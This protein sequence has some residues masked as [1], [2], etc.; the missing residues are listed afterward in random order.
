MDPNSQLYGEDLPTDYETCDACGYDHYYDSLT[1]EVSK[2]IRKAH[3]CEQDNES[4]IAQHI[5]D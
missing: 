1:P 5:G 4:P 2:A 3:S